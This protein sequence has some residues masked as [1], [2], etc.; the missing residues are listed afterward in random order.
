[1]KIRNINILV[2]T[3]IAIFSASSNAACSDSEYRIYQQY[4]KFLDANPSTPDHE[5]R[6]VFAKNIGMQPSALKNLYVR[7]VNRW[8]NQNPSERD[9]YI[10]KL[11]TK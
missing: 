3:F 5:L 6:I 8:A 11:Q 2:A 9:D 1:M 7:C 10:K 4:D